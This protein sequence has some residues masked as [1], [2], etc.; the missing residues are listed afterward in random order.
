M[1][2]AWDTRYHVTL[3]MFADPADPLVNRSW[4]ELRTITPTLLPVEKVRSTFQNRQPCSTQKQQIT[5]T[6]ALT[7]E[8]QPDEVVQD[9]VTYYNALKVL[10]NGSAKAG[11]YIVKVDDKD[12]L[13]APW[14]VNTNYADMSLR[15]ATA[16]GCGQ[17][18]MLEWL[19]EKDLYTRGLMV[20]YMRGGMP[21]GA[22]VGEGHQGH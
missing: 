6:V 22:C 4:W 19:R 8:E 16:R 10:A 9:V 12:V 14:D 17:H 15:K 5:E 7:F 1:R 11:N 20:N 21:H 2:E 13:F 18:N 3:S